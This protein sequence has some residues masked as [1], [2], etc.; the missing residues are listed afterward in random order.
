M[1]QKVPTVFKFLSCWQWNSNAHTNVN[2]VY[3]GPQG[4]TS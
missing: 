1:T 4:V 2:I 3:Y